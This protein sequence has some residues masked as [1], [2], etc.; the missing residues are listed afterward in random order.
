MKGERSGDAIVKRCMAAVS[1]VTGVTIDDMIDVGDYKSP[2]HVSMAKDFVVRLA[3]TRGLMS[4]NSATHAMG[5]HH[6]GYMG[7]R[8]RLDR[9]VARAPD[10]KLAWTR[11]VAKYDEIIEMTK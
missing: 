7:R 1:W 11:C 4:I 9:A 6:A 5:S 10:V 3:T 8:K 2:A